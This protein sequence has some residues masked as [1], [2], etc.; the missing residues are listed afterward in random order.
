MDVSKET[1]TKIQHFSERRQ[2]AEEEYDQQQ[3]DQT[4]IQ[5]FNQKLDATLKELQNQVER[6]DGELERISNTFDLLSIGTDPQSRLSQVRRAK[7]A[8]DS[9]LG[10]EHELPT[11]GSPLPS[12]LAIE[13]ISRLVKESKVSVSMTAEKLSTNRQRLKTEE[14]N[15]RDAQAIRKGLEERIAKIRNE[16]SRKKEKSPSQLAEELIE[17][18][19]AKNKVLD[20]DADKLRASLHDLV[21]EQLAAMLAAEGLGGPTVGDALEIP[22]T[23]LEA[24]YT[25]HG[26]PRKPKASNTDQDGGQQR[27]DQL[28]RRQSGQENGHRSSPSNRREA[29]AAEMHTLLDSLID[30]DTSY[31]DLPRESAASRFLVRAKVAQFHPRDARRLR[32]IDFGRSLSD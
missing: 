4:A 25:N 30:A 12:L 28:M 20:K 11:P 9:L 22:D 16:K 7:K 26:K 5:E 32:L 27:I 6:Q 17:Q 10:S 23:T 18:K 21:D 3:F 8:Y 31:I 24:G 2:K 29:A 14:A 19:R 1:I 15:L 13:E